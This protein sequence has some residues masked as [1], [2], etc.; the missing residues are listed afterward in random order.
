MSAA[1]GGAAG[2]PRGAE[3]AAELHLGD[4]LAA[5]VDGE[6][7]HDSR[8]RVLAHLATCPQCRREADEQRRVKNVLAAAV[9]PGPSE[10]LLA[11][12]QGLPAGDVSP[13]DGPAR[14]GG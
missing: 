7:G 4:R 13:L 6:L 9:G 12:L 10:G 5:F 1:D 2:F 3:Q 14:P 11:R 8:E